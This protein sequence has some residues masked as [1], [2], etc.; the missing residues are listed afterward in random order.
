MGT[1]QFTGIADPFDRLAAVTRR[2]GEN[3][4]ETDELSRLRRDLIA[5]LHGRGFSHAR[6]AE[7][8]GLSRGRIFQ[9]LH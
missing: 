3:S 2:L 1:E 9:L 4:R 8:A 6:L 7:A 5:E